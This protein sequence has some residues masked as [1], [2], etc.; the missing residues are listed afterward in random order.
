[1]TRRTKILGGTG[2]AVAAL[3]AVSSSALAATLVYST[4][5][6]YDWTVPAG[7]TAVDVELWGA[8]GSGIV[9]SGSGAVAP[10]SRPGRTRATLAVT[11]GEV[12]RVVVGGAPTLVNRGAGGFNGG[13]AGGLTGSGGGG[14]GTD[15]RRGGQ[16]LANRVLVAGGGGGGSSFG[17]FYTPSLVGG[18]GG[19]ASGSDGV[20]PGA[21]NGTPGRGATQS[22]GGA[23]GQSQCELD[24][25]PAASG[26]PGTLGQGGAGASGSLGGGGGG[27][28]YGGGGGG[29]PPVGPPCDP[30]I[31]GTLF[32]GGGT[33][34]GG[35]GYGPAGALLESGQVHPDSA[36]RDGYAK[37]RFGPAP[38]TPTGLATVPASPSPS[39]TLTLR[40]S[41]LEGT[42]VEVFANGTC[43]GTPVARVTAATFAGAG[44]AVTVPADQTTAISAR[45]IDDVL[46]SGCSAALSYVARSAPPPA[47]PP[48][49][50]PPDSAP[51]A[52]VPAILGPVAPGP[53]LPDQ[54]SPPSVSAPDLRPRRVS[55]VTERVRMGADG[56]L[57]VSVR[58]R[59]GSRPCRGTL[60]LLHGKTPAGSVRYDVTPGSSSVL[61]PTLRRAV[62]RRVDRAEAVVLRVA[63]TARTIVVRGPRD[64]QGLPPRLPSP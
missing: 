47:G 38:T 42:M 5:G 39:T 51:P 25:Q 50:V 49:V 20:P 45:S 4:A 53:P 28:W 17:P 44:V 52:P 31:I 64:W 61:T 59:A 43:D 30:D 14:G 7:I 13:G 48:V 2:A 18:S 37:L 26:Q 23:G 54:P 56:A 21:S 3:F 60:R 57:A 15:V 8:R 62:R 29:G 32:A 22:A 16:A 58:C 27:G 40:G 10:D 19:G 34:G 35:S 36:Q 1:M 9:D 46:Q 6:T 63:G 11:P 33:G 55:V 24:G 41:A 12:L